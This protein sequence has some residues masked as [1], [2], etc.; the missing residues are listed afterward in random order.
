ML[1]LA[2]AVVSFNAA[3]LAGVFL[4]ARRDAVLVDEQERPMARN[5]A[6]REKR[7][8]VPQPAE[9]ART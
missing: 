9:E 3:C 1:T 2:I 5:G 6:W 8:P 7:V 4:F